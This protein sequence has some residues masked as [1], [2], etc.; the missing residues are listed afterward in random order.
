MFKN[1]QFNQKQLQHKF[2][3]INLKDMKKEDMLQM[4]QVYKNF[5]KKLLK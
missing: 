3:M 5:M 1:K 4:Q 2:I